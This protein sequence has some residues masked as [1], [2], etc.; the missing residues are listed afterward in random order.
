MSD[1]WRFLSYTSLPITRLSTAMHNSQDQNV[2]LFNRVEN[3]IRKLPRQAPTN[4]FINQVPAY[5]SLS[6][7]AELRVSTI[8]R[9]MEFGCGD[10]RLTTSFACFCYENYTKYSTM[11]GGQVS[12][13]C[14]QDPTQAL[15][16]IDVF[17]RYCDLGE[18]VVAR[19][20]FIFCNMG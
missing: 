15:S 1:I 4:I 9:N 17:N 20:M 5:S 7:C 16:A 8:V 13:A 3:S 10:G 19:R 18:G 14:T 11:I 12:S 6:K 2:I